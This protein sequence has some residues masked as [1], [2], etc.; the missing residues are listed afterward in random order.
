MPAP[1]SIIIPTL[2]AAEDLPQC[3]ASLMPGAEAGLIRE[4]LLS[5]GG[6]RDAT[7]DIA[8]AAGAS[9]IQSERGRGKQLATGAKA[10]RGE[11]LLFLHADTSLTRDWVERVR[12]HMANAPGKAAFFTLAFRSDHPMAKH[13]AA[14][15][16]RRAKLLGLPYGDQ[17]LLVPRSLY[18]ETGGYKDMPL[19]ED[20]ALVRA[21]GRRRLSMLS[22]EAR[23]SA[24][25]YERDG[26]RKRSWKNAWLITRYLLGA[27]PEKLAA[28]YR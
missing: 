25:K 17:A 7:A 14:R 20:V 6:S 2:H 15:A 4:V 12:D 11:W 1:L 24:A 10:A 3:L 13:V 21:I 26:W 27:S 28:A 23:T 8:D 16:N 22:A 18:E 19:M 9:I 5:D